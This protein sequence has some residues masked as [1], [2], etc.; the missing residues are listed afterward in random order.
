MT[1]CTIIVLGATGNLAMRKIIPAL[2]SLVQQNNG[3]FLFI[4]AA[5]DTYTAQQL[6]ADAKQYAPSIDADTWKKMRDCTYYQETEVTSVAALERLKT[7]VEELEQK[8]HVWGNRIVYCALPPHL[9]CDATETI[10][11]SGLLTRKHNHATP[12]HRIAYEK[13]FGSDK[14]SAQKINACIKQWFDESQ[15][16]RI[17][18]Y[19]TKELVSN[20]AL[21]RF[22]NSIFEPLWNAQH[23]A[24]VQVL[25]SESVDV[26]GR[27]SY[28]DR[29]GVIKDVVQNH[30]LQLMA[31]TAMEEPRELSGD[32]I[33]DEK[34]RVLTAT[35]IVHTI[36]G[37]YRGYRDEVG[38]ARDSAMPTFAF[39]ELAI[40]NPRWRGVPFYFSTGKRLDHKET[41]IRITFKTVVCALRE[42]ASCASNYVTIRI[43]PDAGFALNLNVKKPETVH[44]TTQVA[45]DFCHSCI[46]P[47]KWE[48]QRIFEEIMT[49]ESSI[50]VRVD[51]IEAAW[52]ITDAI[53]GRSLPVHEYTSGSKGPVSALERAKSLGIWW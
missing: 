11:R 43:F 40:N 45:M 27:G 31:L 48:Y 19:L 17:D 10:G 22:A 24:S 41:V 13:P 37:Q 33:R 36:L 2:A 47:T 34:V 3:R 53:A 42:T 29:Y 32:A 35:K 18:H 14:A 7:V 50:G 1:D 6:L 23:I 30:M 51:E 16:Y 28:Y 9:F 4:G 38:V 46:F 12:Y 21:V 5:R 49:G 8:H 25:L 52:S 26:E 15:V 20:I 44:E 39:M